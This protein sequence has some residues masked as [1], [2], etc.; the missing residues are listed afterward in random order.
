MGMIGKEWVLSEIPD[1]TLMFSTKLNMVIFTSKKLS[2][3][4]S[5][6][7][8]QLSFY[9]MYIHLNFIME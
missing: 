6:I 3:S 7:Q 1:Q 4:L 5:K 9:P 2:D 8:L